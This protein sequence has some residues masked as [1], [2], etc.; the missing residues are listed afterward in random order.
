MK[1]RKPGRCGTWLWVYPDVVLETYGFLA[2]PISILSM[3]A[4]ELSLDAYLTP[5]TRLHD[6]LPGSGCLGINALVCSSM[7]E[8]CSMALVSV[9]ALTLLNVSESLFLDVVGC[10]VSIVYATWGGSTF[11]RDV[12]LLSF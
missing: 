11:G 2:F 12:V 5:A 10:H 3:L 1:S 6:W 7:A 8:G 4:L 9:H